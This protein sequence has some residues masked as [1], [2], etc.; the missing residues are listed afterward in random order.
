MAKPPSWPRACALETRRL[1]LEPLRVE[2]AEEAAALFDDAALHEFIGGE[3][4]TSLQL[5]S[6]YAQLESEHCASGEE[7]WLN[8]T[9]RLRQTQAMVGAVQATLRL[10]DE[11]TV[12]HVAW[13][14]ATFYQRR[15]YA[16]EAAGAMIEW[17]GERG[18]RHFVAHVNPEHA[19]SILVAE[20]VGLAATGLGADGEMVW[21]RDERQR[22]G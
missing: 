3:P 21:I 2:H 13:T 12:A 18:V 17:L 10:S 11:R 1:T 6:R 4:Q 19:A 20:R 14:T 7:G 16:T 9:V 15:G 22:T 8:W 5:R